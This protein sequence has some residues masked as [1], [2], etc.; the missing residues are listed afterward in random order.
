MLAIW[1]A[2]GEL[3]AQTLP[4]PMATVK[5]FYVGC[6]ESSRWIQAQTVLL[7]GHFEA[8]LCGQIEE[9]QLSSKP[10]HLLLRL[11]L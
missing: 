5:P 8:I 6:L 4:S 1:R 10:K 3:Q 2:P 7:G 9:L 11:Q